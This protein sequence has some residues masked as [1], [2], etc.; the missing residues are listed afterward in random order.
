[1][2]LVSIIIPTYN[3]FKFL[4]NAIN[5][6][7]QQTYENIEIIIINDCSTEQE[8]Y[9]YNFKENFGD[10]IFIIHLPRN[11][12]SYLGKVCGGGNARNIGMMLAKG[13]YIAF[14][15]DDDYYL[16]SKIEKQI[17]AMKQYNCKMCCTES[18]LGAGVYNNEKS[19]QRY[20]H[21]GFYWSSLQN[22]CFKNNPELL[23]KMYKEEINIWEKESIY[24]HNCII[25]SS[26]VIHKDLINNTRYFPLKA[27]A[28]DW[29]YWKE[30]IKYSNCIYIREPL[31]YFD[32]N[33]GSGRN[34]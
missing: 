27:Y 26:V 31:M 15:D 2:D 1:M 18:Y 8:Y 5:S 34:Y 3:R 11:S 30:L 24:I 4:L 25:S 32:R 19:Y 14:L 12:R 16:P 28:E 20:H 21:N 7:K 29:A 33:H 13:Q 6:I 9:N 17:A 22:R 23:E 10:N